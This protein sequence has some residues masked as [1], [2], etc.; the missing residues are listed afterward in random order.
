[1]AGGPAALPAAHPARDRRRHLGVRPVP[2]DPGDRQRRH[3]RADPHVQPDAGPAGGGVPRAAAVPRRRRPRAEDPA[4]RP[5]GPPRAPRPPRPRRGRG[6]P[7]AAAGRDRPDV[8]PGQRADHA[9]QDRPPGL[10]PLRGRRAGAVL[11]HAAGEV[12]RAWAAHLGRR[13]GQRPGR[14]DRRAA[15]HPGDARA[16]AERR[17]AHRRGR[18]DRPRGPRRPARRPALGA[19]HRPGRRRRAQDTHLRPVPPGV[20]D[21]DHAA[22]GGGALFI[23]VLPHRRKDE[24]WPAS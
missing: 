2:A 23:L 5:A 9:G 6:H 24:P 3:H 11:R 4:D 15:D 10:L 16:R 22:V 1:M 8:A 7:D 12:P 18:R 21:Q 17:E 14:A 13:R 20:L 19:R